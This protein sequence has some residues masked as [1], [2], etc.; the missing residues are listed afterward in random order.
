MSQVFDNDQTEPVSVFPAG[1][2]AG[3]H[4]VRGVA[5]IYI[6]TPI[7]YLSIKP[8]PASKGKGFF[9]TAADFFYCFLKKN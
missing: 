8:C 2:A 4:H 9:L 3:G 7:I 1:C 6:L 5:A